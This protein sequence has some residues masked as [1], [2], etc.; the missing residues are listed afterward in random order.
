MS[1]LAS[2]VATWRRIP[3]RIDRDS[4]LVPLSARRRRAS[5]SVRPRGAGTGVEVIRVSD[6]ATGAVMFEPMRKTAADAG[7]SGRLKDGRRTDQT[8]QASP[9]AGA[10]ARALGFRQRTIRR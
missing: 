3:T 10:G 6:S 1:G 9:D 8:Y 2:C 7:A 5:A 4:S